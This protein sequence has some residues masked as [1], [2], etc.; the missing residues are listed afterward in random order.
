M[1]AGVREGVT[2]RGRA[3]CVSVLWVRVSF[4][5]CFHQQVEQVQVGGEGCPGHDE[6][7][8]S[9]TALGQH[10]DAS[11]SRSA[12]PH[13]PIDFLIGCTATPGAK[14]GGLFFPPTC[15]WCALRLAAPALG[16][17]RVPLPHPHAAPRAELR[18]PVQQ[19]LQ[20]VLGSPRV[21]RPL[22]C[23]H[24]CPVPSP[25]PI[26]LGHAPQVQELTSALRRQAASLTHLH[27][28]ACPP[29]CNDD[30]ARMALPLRRLSHLRLVGLSGVTPALVPALLPGHAVSAGDEGD[31]CDRRGVH[32]G[33]PRGAEEEVGGGCV[34]LR[35]L[36]LDSCGGGVPVGEELV[37]TAAP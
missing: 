24:V 26:S 19:S 20:P 34:A 4:E 33:G 29:M 16:C 1:P 14:R 11:P 18:Q 22:P 10:L 9:V 7:Q 25:A 23:P 27:V 13:H 3:L 37:F 12:L 30:V 5:R 32:A 8:C 21:P 35:C 15:H 28:Q 6:S 31:G 36:V 17:P 2:R